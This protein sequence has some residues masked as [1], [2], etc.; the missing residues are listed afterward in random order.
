MGEF[1]DEYP[2]NLLERI[3]NEGG[4]YEHMYVFR[5]APYGFNNPD[6]FLSTILNDRKRGIKKNRD[7]NNLSTY[8]TSCCKTK[9]Y[10]YSLKGVCF[11][12]EPKAEV[13]EGEIRPDLGP[14]RYDVISPHIDWWLF[15]DAAPW[16]YFIRSEA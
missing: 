4:K 9:E 16:L 2:E 10:A 7:L 14:C 13:A 5:V 12:K 8:S 1:P 11:R 15:K 3:L 6:S